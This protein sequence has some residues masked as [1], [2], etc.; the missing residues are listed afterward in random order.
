M[1]QILILIALILSALHYNTDYIFFSWWL[2]VSICFIPL[3]FYYKE[4]TSNLFA[5]CLCGMGA[6]CTYVVLSTFSVYGTLPPGARLG[7]SLAAAMN[8]MC[9]FV[10]ITALIAMPKRY[11]SAVIDAI[12]L[13]C[14]INSIYVIVNWV[15]DIRFTNSMGHS[16]FLDYSGMNGVYIAVCLVPTIKALFEDY[17]NRAHWIVLVLG[18]AAL[19]IS[20]GSILWGVVSCGVLGVVLGLRL[21]GKTL[22]KLAP[23]AIVPILIA[24]LSEGSNVLDSGRRFE[25]Y[26]IFLNYWLSSDPWTIAFGFGPSEFQIISGMA[27]R[28]ANF[29][30]NEN[31]SMWAWLWAHSEPIQ[32]LIEYGIIGAILTLA[33]ISE[34]LI[35]L[36]R[37]NDKTVFA[38]AISL[39]GSAIFDY[40]CRLFPTAILVMWCMVY[41]YQS[42]ELT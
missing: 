26:R 8:F 14:L 17:K 16:G 39:V 10:P 38:I 9:V 32:V 29:M 12:P 7:Y 36:Y 24:V 2:G 19:V 5:T 6:Y 22:L 33:L 37:K 31:G 27:Q 3:F 35:K 15:F 28:A 1:Q 18:L 11:L 4:K 40:P 23:L 42:E 20:K 34:T 30:T 41:A 13:M 21:S 25:A